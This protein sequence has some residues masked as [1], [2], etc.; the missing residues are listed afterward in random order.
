MV[1][2]PSNCHIVTLGMLWNMQD[3]VHIGHND[4]PGTQLILRHCGLEYT[5]STSSAP[6][7]P[8]RPPIQQGECQVVSA[9]TVE[10]ITNLTVNLST[11]TKNKNNKIR[12][13]KSNVVRN[14]QPLSRHQIPRQSPQSCIMLNVA[15]IMA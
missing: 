10:I 1:S 5:S 7:A 6:M 12:Q 13:R 11:N 3:F 9:V 4:K 14:R 15:H 2:H 8:H